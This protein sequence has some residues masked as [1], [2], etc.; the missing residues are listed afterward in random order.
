MMQSSRQEPHRRFFWACEA[1]QPSPIVPTVILYLGYHPV[2]EV[3]WKEGTQ[4]WTGRTR[5]P[6]SKPSHPEVCA[7]SSLADA[8][9]AVEDSI[10]QWL[11]DA[12]VDY[13]LLEKAECRAA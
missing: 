12:G 11:R 4:R 9:A 1:D 7:K 10:K 3:F 13:K 8:Q 6:R 5:L 2:G